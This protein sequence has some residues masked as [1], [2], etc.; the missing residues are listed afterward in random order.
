MKKTIIFIS[1]FTLVICSLSFPAFAK[2]DGN[3]LTTEQKRI[4][5]NIIEQYN[6]IYEEYQ[7][8]ADVSLEILLSEY[9]SLELISSSKSSY[10]PSNDSSLIFSSDGIEPL[11]SSSDISFN[12]NIVYDSDWNT[13]VYLGSWN[14]TNGQPDETNLEPWDMIGF[15][16][17]DKDELRAQEYIV[18]GYN[19]SGVRQVYYNTDSNTV[20]GSISKGEDTLWGVAFWHDESNVDNGTFSA[21]LYWTSGATAKVMLKYGHSWTEKTITGVGG[22]ASID[23]GG[24]S[25]SWDTDVLHW[26]SIVT[27]SGV[28]LP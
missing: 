23:G 17:Q 9:P 1:I 20:S 19:T 16:T 5:L 15:Y 18:R 12:D 24:F 7:G 25:V 26:P 28:R 2:N 8:N 6:E 3:E 13:Y 27:S 14:W 11:S 21:P 4:A 10:E 22:S